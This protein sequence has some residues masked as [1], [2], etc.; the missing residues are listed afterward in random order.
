MAGPASAGTNQ[1]RLTATLIEKKAKRFTPAGVPVLEVM[2]AYSGE[3]NEAA[4][5]RQV[6]F[7]AKGKAVGQVAER[8]E[9]LALGAR[10][11]LSG[12]L[13]QAR[14]HSRQLVIHLTDFEL[15]FEHG[16]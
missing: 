7:E 4:I 2:L 9:G 15:E 8:V 3:V 14:Q 6:Q 12:F 5:D 13:A 1:V 11:H 16:V 10:I